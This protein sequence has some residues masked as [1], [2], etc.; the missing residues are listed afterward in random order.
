MPL[1]YKKILQ[2][3]SQ[4]EAIAAG[5]VVLEYLVVITTNQ[6]YFNWITDTWILAG[7][8]GLVYWHRFKNERPITFTLFREIFV[9]TPKHLTLILLIVYA[10]YTFYSF[11]YGLPGWMLW[12]T[13]A[14]AILYFL[15]FKRRNI[16]QP[17]SYRPLVSSGFLPLTIALV[18][19]ITAMHKE[20]G[21]MQ[22]GGGLNSGLE[23]GYTYE[24]ETSKGGYQW[25]YR[26]RPSTTYTP[27]TYIYFDGR[28]LL[29]GFELTVALLFMFVM[30]CLSK[31]PGVLLP[32]LLFLCLAA[33]WLWVAEGYDNMDMTGIWMLLAGFALLGIQVF[34][35]QQLKSIFPK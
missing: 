13:A 24:Y 17:L 9:F 10:L 33:W 1:D 16:H 34:F 26:Y 5:L 8:L 35:P 27:E 7:V 19:C 32:K 2:S 30:M 15:A 28:E 4:L 22:T 25:D 20:M 23:L 29:L 18:L 31:S 21:Y 6:G 14:Q 11:S 12:L 3:P